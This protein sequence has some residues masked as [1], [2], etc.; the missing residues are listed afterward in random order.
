MDKGLVG[1]ARK[2]RPD[3]CICPGHTFHGECIEIGELLFRHGVGQE[4]GLCFARAAHVFQNGDR[5]FFKSARHQPPRHFG[6]GAGVGGEDNQLCAGL[7]E[8]FDIGGV[9]AMQGERIAIGEGPA[10]A[11]GGI[12]RRPR[13]GG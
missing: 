6:N 5:A 13:D 12:G 2:A 9:A 8:G 3:F 11:R 10:D 7:D 4:S 1:K